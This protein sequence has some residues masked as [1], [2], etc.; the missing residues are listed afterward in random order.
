[1]NVFIHK[2]AEVSEKASLGEGTKVWNG[3]QIRENSKIGKECVISKGVYVDSGVE[4]GDNVKIQN[5]VSIYEGVIIKNGVF[6]GPHVCFTNDTNPRAIKLD[7]TLK[8]DKDW[9]ISKTIIHE[10]AS[11]G[12]NSTIVSGISIGKFAMVGAGS[13]VTKDVSDNTLVFGNP[14]SVKGFVCKCGKIKNDS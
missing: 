11:I 7:G 3:A 2:T 8:T 9:E 5:N 4:V 13:V 6:I 14:A 12:A 1:M 10:G